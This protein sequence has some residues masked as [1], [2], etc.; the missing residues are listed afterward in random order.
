MVDVSRL[1]GLQ[2]DSDVVIDKVTTVR[3]Q[4]VHRRVGRLSSEQLVELERSL[5]TFLGL[6]R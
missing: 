5:V 4:H 6:A 2:H 3:R 1:S